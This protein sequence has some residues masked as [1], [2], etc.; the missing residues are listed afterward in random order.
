MTKSGKHMKKAS[1]LIRT[2]AAVMLF[3]QLTFVE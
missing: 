2:L 3:F 1:A